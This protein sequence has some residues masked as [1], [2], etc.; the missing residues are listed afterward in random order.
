MFGSGGI[1]KRSASGLEFQIGAALSIPVGPIR[2]VPR[3]NVGEGSFTSG[4]VNGTSR[5]I[6]SADRGTHTFV[7]VGL[8]AY[9]SLD[10]GKKPQ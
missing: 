2:L 1:Q 5:D 8:A 10:F 3:L 4:Q 6:P 9:Y 7:F